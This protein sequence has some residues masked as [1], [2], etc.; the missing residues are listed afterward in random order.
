LPENET[1]MQYISRWAE[2]LLELKTKTDVLDVK[3]QLQLM[4]A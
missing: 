2:I 1:A 4:A 3:M